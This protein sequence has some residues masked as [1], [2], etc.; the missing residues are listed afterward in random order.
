[1]IRQVDTGNVSSRIIFH[2]KIYFLELAKEVQ[3]AW[4]LSLMLPLSKISFVTITVKS[5]KVLIG[6]TI[7]TSPN[8]RDRHFTWS[9]EPREGLAACS[10]KEVPSFLSHFSVRPWVIVRPRESNPP[11]PARQ[12][13]ALPTELFLPRI[14]TT[15]LRWFI[16]TLYHMRMIE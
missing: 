5:T 8:G 14:K 3:T 15:C 7:F 10:A 9:S 13:N 11:P 1:M 6:D 12:S 4:H 16:F 2:C